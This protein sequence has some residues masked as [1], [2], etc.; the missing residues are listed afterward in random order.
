MVKE[1]DMIDVG[2]VEAAVNPSRTIRIVENSWRKH[3]EHLKNSIVQLPFSGEYTAII[4]TNFTLVEGYAGDLVIDRVADGTTTYLLTK[5]LRFKD[6]RIYACYT[7]NGRFQSFVSRPVV[8]FHYT[9]LNKDGD[10]R[11]CLGAVKYIAP[12]TIDS[13]REIC[14]RIIHSQ[15]VIYIGSL[16][17]AFVPHGYKTLKNIIK[18][19]YS[20]RDRRCKLI[21]EGFMKP[22]LETEG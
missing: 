10:R 4:G 21:A 3:V 11:L 20:W 12:E 22:M 2:M 1:N 17:S 8:G 16:G 13:V 15:R 19:D 14:S 18:S 7:K 9:D 6:Y 5:P